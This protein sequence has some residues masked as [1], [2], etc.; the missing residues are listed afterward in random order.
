MLGADGNAPLK[1]VLLL[2]VEPALDAAD[3]AAAQ[4]ALHAAEMVIALS[5]FKSAAL[6]AADV[7]LPVAPFTETSGSFVNAE[8]R[9]QSFHG[10]VKP[11]GETRPAWKVLRVLGNLLDLEGFAFDTSEQVLE[12]ALGDTAALEPRLVNHSTSAAT[13]DSDGNGLQRIADVPIY[14][15]DTLVRRAPA[16]Q[17]TADARA[18]VASLPVALWAQL[19]LQPGDRV[20]VA[21]GDAT[22][23]LPAR[24]DAGLA[25]N[26]VRVPAG[27]PDTV[28]LG[29]MFGVITV[30]KA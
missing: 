25:A 10:V 21:Q 13:R 17:R 23:V 19:G 29:A 7:L 15:A 1:A 30:A 6:D 4:R 16:L 28:A 8:G 9:V 20:R 2:D 12:Q 3:G 18:P 27:H 14:A 22:V 26:A 11:L 24:P 5:P